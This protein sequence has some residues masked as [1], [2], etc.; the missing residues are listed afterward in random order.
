MLSLLYGPTLI[1]DGELGCSI[2]GSVARRH[3][4]AMGA[5]GRSPWEG[6]S[7]QRSGG[8]GGSASEG[9]AGLRAEG[10]A[11]AKVWER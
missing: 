10:P 3:R 1:Q 2:P 5:Q 6:P 8:P 11:C 7:L 9:G 4:G